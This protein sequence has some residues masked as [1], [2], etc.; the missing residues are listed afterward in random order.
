MQGITDYANIIQTCVC[1]AGSA[2]CANS[3]ANEY[4]A[5]AGYVASTGD[6]CDN[7]LN[8]QLGTGGSCAHTVSTQCA[9]DTSCN[10]YIVC[11]D[12]CP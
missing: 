7:C 12:G 6:A 8:K 11:A 1:T 3:C 9:A 4:C 10:D 2:P 5:Q